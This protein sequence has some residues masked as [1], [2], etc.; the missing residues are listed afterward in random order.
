MQIVIDIP[1]SL[2]A[3]LQKIQNGSIASGRILKIVK[4]GKRTKVEE[5]VKDLIED[6]EQRIE[7]MELDLREQKVNMYLSAKLGA[8]GKMV[9]DLN[10]ILEE[11]NEQ[12]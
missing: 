3:N 11:K 7:N 4:E 2:Y 5:R 9:A 6:Y 8:Y 12:E 10:D 1:N